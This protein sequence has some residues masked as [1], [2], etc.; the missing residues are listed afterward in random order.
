MYGD[1]YLVVSMAENSEGEILGSI[2]GHPWLKAHNDPN[3]YYDVQVLSN[4][5][6]ILFDGGMTW[7][8]VHAQRKMSKG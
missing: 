6:A 4:E 7:E 2:P 3:V 1:D 5:L 8:Q